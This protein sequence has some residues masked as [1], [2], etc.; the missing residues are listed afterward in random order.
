MNKDD[1]RIAL[2]A[3]L[4]QG[5]FL[6]VVGGDTLP[7]VQST[8]PPKRI[9]VDIGGGRIW[10]DALN[11][12]WVEWYLRGPKEPTKPIFIPDNPPA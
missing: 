8:I 5:E 11:P 9:S 2:L 3:N 12:A 1:F 7:P 6:S 4:T 10:A